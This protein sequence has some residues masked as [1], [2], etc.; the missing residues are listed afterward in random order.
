MDKFLE[1]SKIPKLTQ[2]YVENLKSWTLSLKSECATENLHTKKNLG[3][4]SPLR[5]SP[6]IY[7]RNNLNPIQIQKIEKENTS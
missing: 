6:N 2:E 3:S 5:I 7:G 4:D 1:K